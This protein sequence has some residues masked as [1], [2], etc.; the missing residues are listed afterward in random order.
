MSVISSG[1]L[2][3]EHPELVALIGLQP[4]L[5]V[6]PQALASV[7]AGGPAGPLQDQARSMVRVSRILA[8]QVSAY[9]GL[10]EVAEAS[11]RSP[12]SS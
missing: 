9:V 12:R 10:I 1:D 3:R 6:L 11:P 8:D 7:H 4:L 2:L 5:E